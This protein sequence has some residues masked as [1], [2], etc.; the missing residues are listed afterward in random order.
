MSLL[1]G[2]RKGKDPSKLFFH[3]DPRVGG[4]KEKAVRN[5][6]RRRKD[7]LVR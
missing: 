3:V 2:K 7:K 1:R 4:N 6:L 5:V